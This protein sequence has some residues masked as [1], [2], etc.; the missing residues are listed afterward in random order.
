MKVQWQVSPTPKRR[1]AKYTPSGLKLECA[2]QAWRDGST[3][4]NIRSKMAPFESLDRGLKLSH[5][6]FLK[7]YRP[8]G[9]S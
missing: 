6:S 7:S 1:A 4:L 8:N 3:G 5:L 9:A 2:T